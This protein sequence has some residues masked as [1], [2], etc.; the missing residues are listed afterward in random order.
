MIPA[1]LTLSDHQPRFLQ[2]RQ[3]ALNGPFGDPHGGRHLP[4]GASRVGV[5][6][7]QDMGVI[8]EE[9]PS[10]GTVVLRAVGVR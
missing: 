4:P 8:G 7:D 5:Q 3:D 9:G 2:T 10:H 6:A 1:P